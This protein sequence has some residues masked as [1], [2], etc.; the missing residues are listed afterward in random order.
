MPMTARCEANRKTLQPV[1]G[2]CGHLEKQTMAHR[3]QELTNTEVFR[4][5]QD[6]LTQDFGVNTH[7]ATVIVMP[8]LSA[9]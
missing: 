5:R 2:R 3:R 4:F 7:P 9:Q 1:A 8:V 6:R